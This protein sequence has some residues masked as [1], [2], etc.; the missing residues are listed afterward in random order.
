MLEERGLS[1]EQVF[2]ADESGLYWKLMPSKTLVTSRE[3]EAKALKQPK[4]KVTI[5]ACA[6]A[7]GSIKL[8]LVFIHKYANPRCFKNI[9]KK[10]FLCSISIKEMPWMDS[11]I[12][13]DWF[14]NSFFPFCRKALIEKGFPQKA[15]LLL[16]KAPSHPDVND[17][18]S[19]DGQITCLPNTTSVLQP[20]DQ[21]VLENIKKCY[22]RDLLLRLLDEGDSD[23]NIAEFRKTLNIKDAVLITAKSWNEVEQQT[24]AKSW[25]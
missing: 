20:M 3:K 7:S 16:D 4:D 17:L 21:G 6:N 13:N 14:H 8:P 10:T 24:I 1:R 12:F 15:I 18:T 5:M 9:D 19:E 2:N 25:K 23:S 22:K 11:S